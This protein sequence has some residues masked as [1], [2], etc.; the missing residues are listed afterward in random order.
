MHAFLILLLFT[1]IRP[2]AAGYKAWFDD[3][4]RMY[5]EQ[6]YGQMDVKYVLSPNVIRMPRPKCMF[7]HCVLFNDGRHLN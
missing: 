3:H 4:K 1:L 5:K 6:S 7:L 2:N